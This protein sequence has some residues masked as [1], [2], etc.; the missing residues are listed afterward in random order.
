MVTASIT[1]S[2][3]TIVVSFILGILGAFPLTDGAVADRQDG[4][5]EPSNI[6]EGMGQVSEGFMVCYTDI[7]NDIASFREDPDLERAEARKEAFRQF[8]EGLVH[9]YE[10]FGERMEGMLDSVIP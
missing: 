8:A 9:Q 3:I 1:F 7:I 2:V 4:D 5:G 6:S 10:G